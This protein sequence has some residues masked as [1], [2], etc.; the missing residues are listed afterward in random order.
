MSEQ[1]EQREQG[2]HCPKCQAEAS[3]NVRHAWCDEC[4]WRGKPDTLVTSVELD[5]DNAD[6]ATDDSGDDATDD[7][8]DDGDDQAADDQEGDD[9][10]GDG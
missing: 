5:A 8:T 4:G 10:D 3:Y 1:G 6:D 2:E 7:A 9:Q